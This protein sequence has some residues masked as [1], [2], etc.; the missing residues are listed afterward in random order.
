MHLFIFNTCYL[1]CSKYIISNCGYLIKNN[2]ALEFPLWLSGLRIWHSVHEGAGSL[3][4]NINPSI[5]FLAIC[6]FFTTIYCPVLEHI[7]LCRLIAELYCSSAQWHFLK[8]WIVG[9][10]FTC[11]MERIRES[12]LL[13]CLEDLVSNNISCT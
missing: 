12:S 11:K 10:Y 5:D 4:S 8:C 9:T 1:L 3:N 2:I 7:R 6:L 13:I